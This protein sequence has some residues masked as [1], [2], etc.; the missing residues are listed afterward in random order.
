MKSLSIKSE[1]C[2]LSKNSYSV[3]INGKTVSELVL[4]NLPADLK[5]YKDYPVKIQ[6]SI[7]FLGQEGINVETDGYKL[8][9]EV[10]EGT[11]GTSEGKELEI[12]KLGEI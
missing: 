11:K 9:E 5:D 4:N 6:I 8:E 1:N 7:E 12:E 10:E 3:D 2:V